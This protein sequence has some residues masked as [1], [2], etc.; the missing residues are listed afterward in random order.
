MALRKSCGV[1]PFLVEAGTVKI[2]LLQ[3]L[4]GHWGFPK[5]GQESGEKDWET[6]RRELWEEVGIADFEVVDGVR[7]SHSYEFEKG[8]A[9]VQ[10]EVVYFLGRVAY[11]DLKIQESE[12]LSAKWLSVEEVRRNLAH[13]ESIE[14]LE[15][16]A[17]HIEK[18][19]GS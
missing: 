13:K 19:L 14:I 7:L 9:T 4:D 17:S 16:A 2:L 15:T 18:W 11:S 10:K 8:G 1:I 12:L 3:H 6:A 5:G